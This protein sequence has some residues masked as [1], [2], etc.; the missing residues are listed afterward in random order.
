MQIFTPIYGNAPFSVFSQK[1]RKAALEEIEI[2]EKI[3]L[4]LCK[5]A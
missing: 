3:R 5:S 4:H 1:I 2:L